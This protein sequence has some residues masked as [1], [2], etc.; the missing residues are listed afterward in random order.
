[1]PYIN[2]AV[3]LRF[4]TDAH[5]CLE[6][7]QAYVSN[8]FSDRE[9]AVA[10]TI[11]LGPPLFNLGATARIDFEYSLIIMMVLVTRKY[12]KRIQKLRIFVLCEDE[13]HDSLLIFVSGVILDLNS[14]TIALDAAVI[15][16]TEH[17]VAR[18][19]YDIICDSIDPG[20]IEGIKVSRQELLVWKS[21]LPAFVERCRT[22][23]H[24]PN[25]YQYIQEGSAPLPSGLQ[26]GG[27]P[28]CSCGRGFLPV[29]FARHKDLKPFGSF[30]KKY[31]TRPLLSPTFAVPR[32][33]TYFSEMKSV[34]EPL[35]NDLN[36]ADAGPC[37]NC[38]VPTRRDFAEL[39]KP[40]LKC[41][42]GFKV[43]HYSRRCQHKHWNTGHKSACTAIYY[44]QSS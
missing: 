2:S 18:F 30:I 43:S 40:L 23:S 27:S 17:G 42:K 26:N 31:A 28:I 16:L 41:E 14:R 24:D 32:I 44:P 34:K 25:C 1:M 7:A 36:P 6:W 33:E 35:P 4:D 37:V 5:D 20:T 22:W 8:M 38:G 15:P 13:R 21:I 11:R 19:R 9:L 39:G 29:D 12:G 10:S 3:V